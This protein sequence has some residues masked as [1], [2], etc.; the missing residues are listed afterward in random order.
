MV[1]I[2]LFIPLI[3]IIF[4]CKTSLNSSMQEAWKTEI[5]ALQTLK[6]INESSQ[7]LGTTNKVNT[8]MHWKEKWV[9]NI[10]QTIGN[11]LT[12]CPVL[13]VLLANSSCFS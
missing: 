3:F 9:K 2:A 4:F 5:A 6:T 10:V 7:L 1:V 8:G 12:A 11:C 13:S